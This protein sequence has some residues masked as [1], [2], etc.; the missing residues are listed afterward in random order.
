MSFSDIFNMIIIVALV[1]ICVESLF[2]TV[3]WLIYMATEKEKALAGSLDSLIACAVGIV[4][5]SVLCIIDA[6][7]RWI[8]AL[9]AIC[10]LLS[11]PACCF[12]ILTPKGI[13]RNFALKSR[14]VPTSELSYEFADKDLVMHFNNKPKPVKYRLGIKNI[15]TVKMLADWYPK[16]GYTNPLI[17]DE[18][19]SD[20]NTEKE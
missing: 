2:I 11:L 18:D 16:H 7:M 9:T 8:Y 13:C 20:D 1:V 5:F 10:E 12:S 4:I 15:K 3:R 17:P 19:N 14:Y 6:K